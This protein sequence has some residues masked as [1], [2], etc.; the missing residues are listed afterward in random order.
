MIK[1]KEAVNQDGRTSG[2]TVPNPES[3]EALVR[4]VCDQAKVIPQQVRY[5]EA[6]GTG[7]AVG[8]PLECKALGT[9]LGQDRSP[10]N[11]CLVGSVKANIG[12]LE[13]AAGVASVI[14]TSLCLKHK[15]IP[16]VA[17]LENPNPNIP[18]ET[19]GLRLPRK[20]EP[21]P[22]GK[23][24]AYIGIN[25][26][27]YG[28]TNAHAILEEAPVIEPSLVEDAPG[29]PY[30]LPLSARSEK[31]L[32]ALAQ[33]YIDFLSEAK[34][35]P[36]RDICYS[37]SVRREHHNH[38]LALIAD[39]RDGMVEQLQSFVNGQRG[40]LLTGQIVPGQF[41]PP[42]FV[43]TG[44]G[45]QWWAMGHELLQHEPLFRKVAEEC[46][47]IFQRL[48]GSMPHDCQNELTSRLPSWV[49]AWTT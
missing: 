24:P 9:V 32:S 10:D 27:G 45:P 21:M 3:Q 11:A 8:D 25:S 17:N 41:A 36:L 12:H 43:F 29:T 44:M 34:A 18:F 19:L 16:P 2:I 20:L 33:S 46:D 1:K 6:H 42:V 39:S 35:P 38:R 14:K 22:K 28:G 5:V 7:T 15:Q 30:L 31:A 49:I 13:A 4:Q 48:A 40:H 47:A 23:G 37:A 26:F